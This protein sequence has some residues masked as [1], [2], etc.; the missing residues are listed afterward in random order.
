MAEKE[1]HRISIVGLLILCIVVALA[2]LIFLS[3]YGTGGHDRRMSMCAANLYGIGKGILMYQ[4][5]NE[6]KFP[7]LYTEGDL[8][9]SL[10]ETTDA[11]RIE[12]LNANAM[13]N[14]WLMIEKGSISEDLFKCPSDEDWAPRKDI[15]S[16]PGLKKYGWN[17]WRN[18]SYGMHKPYGDKH[19]GPLTGGLKGS[20]PIFADKNHHDDDKPGTVYYTSKSD[21]REPGNHPRDGFNYLTYGSAVLKRRYDHGTVGRYSA[22][23]IDGDDIYVAQDKGGTAP[24]VVT[25]T[26]D[27][28]AETDSFILPWRPGP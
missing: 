7:L 20:F 28:D 1:P 19:A 23:G 16:G 2:I 10:N 24:G 27:P 18:F 17:S 15:E 12:D 25:A 9:A 4:A 6:D 11:D 14:V 3:V 22:C 8:M 13:Q 5:E 21:R 26:A